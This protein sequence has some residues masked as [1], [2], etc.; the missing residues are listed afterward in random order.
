MHG[1]FVAGG[2]GLKKKNNVR[3]LRAIDIAPTISFLMNIPGPQNARGGSSTTSS[4]VGD[5]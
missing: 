5:T 2:P 3:D 4:R 1:T